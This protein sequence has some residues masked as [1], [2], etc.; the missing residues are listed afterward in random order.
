M[1]QTE[2]KFPLKPFLT[3]KFDKF[4]SLF[5]TPAIS[6]VR[7][8]RKR[9]HHLPVDK[10]R[11]FLIHLSPGK[12]GFPSDPISLS[13]RCWGHRERHTK[14][15]SKDRKPKKERILKSY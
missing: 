5:I 12:L 14:T 4:Q 3:S 10:V 13:I 1:D 7:S 2:R 6:P 8:C 15:K 11:E 9:L